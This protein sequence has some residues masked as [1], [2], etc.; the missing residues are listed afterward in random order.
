MPQVDFYVLQDHGEESRHRFA[1]R[2]AEKAYRLSNKVHVEVPDA[3]S[4][5]RLDEL[6]WTFRDGSFLPHKIVDGRNETVDCPISIGSEASMRPTADLF[7]NLTSEYPAD[8]GAFARVAEIVT[9]DEDSKLR[10]RKRF[11]SYRDAGHVLETHKL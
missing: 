11:T 6:M 7:I 9:S 2:L 8:I 1:C 10:S 4:A 5:R 3:T